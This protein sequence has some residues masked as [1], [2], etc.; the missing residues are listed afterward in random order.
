MTLCG[1]GDID[2]LSNIDDTFDGAIDWGTCSDAN[3]VFS[4]WIGTGDTVDWIKLPTELAAG[5]HNFS[6]TTDGD[7]VTFE[8]YQ[9]AEGTSAD[10]KYS[11][12]FYTTG[13]GSKSIKLN[14]GVEYFIKASTKK[15]DATY[16]ITIA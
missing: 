6:Y 11:T 9:R 4:N 2:L 15:T 13:S 7:M 10:P 12:Y 14:A 1:A 8:V 16:S 5:R 3:G